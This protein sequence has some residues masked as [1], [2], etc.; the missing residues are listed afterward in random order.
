MNRIKEFLIDSL[1]ILHNS[2]KIIV[3]I[4]SAIIILVVLLISFG[5]M[6]KI[7][8][9][10]NIKNQIAKKQDLVEQKIKVS[11]QVKEWTEEEYKCLVVFSSAKENIKIKS[12][13]F[14]KENEETRKIKVANNEGKQQIGIDYAI[15]KEDTEKIF[16]IETT[17]G[18][19]VE[20]EIVKY[21]ENIYAYTTIKLYEEFE[22][23]YTGKYRIECWGAT[24][25]NATGISQASGT[26]GQRATGKGGK[27]GYTSGETYLQKGEKLY[28]YVGGKGANAIAYRDSI[29]G[30]N[31]G[32]LGT[33]DNTDDEA[34]GAGGGATDIRL[35]AGEWNNFESLKSRIMVA[36]GGAG[37]SWKTDGGAG[38][39]WEGLTNRQYSLPG[40]QIS[41]YKF[42]VGQ[43]GYGRGSSDGVGGAG[44]RILWR[45]NK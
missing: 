30:Y 16:N 24:G 9:I 35:V 27:G 12:I 19:I 38:G 23:K 32:G 1:K 36:G 3:K 10:N 40:T 37:A 33:W 21:M 20:K 7:G 44:S 29:G 28:V 14:P 42:G 4:V 22:A 45:N 34:A 15:K 17:D 13:E 2:K 11:V 25:G 6:D 18:E 43:D 41:G 8:N 39:G 31:G 5:N 26:S